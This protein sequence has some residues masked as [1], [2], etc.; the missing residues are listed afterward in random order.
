MVTSAFDFK[1][2]R[3]IRP[4]RGLYKEYVTTIDD[5]LNK[6]EEMMEDRI[7]ISDSI[8]DGFLVYEMFGDGEEGELIREKV[9]TWI[10]DNRMEVTNAVQSF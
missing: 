9:Q 2:E 7:I 4:I 5:F 3:F 1:I 10:C 8:R 6:N